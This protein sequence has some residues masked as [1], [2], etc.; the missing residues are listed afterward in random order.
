M[1]LSSGAE[2]AIQQVASERLQRERLQ[3][4]ERDMVRD[5][6]REKTLGRLTR[7]RLSAPAASPIKIGQ[8]AGALKKKYESTI[9]ISG[10][11]D[12]WLQRLLTDT[13][14]NGYD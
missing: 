3:A 7:L 12:S 5:L 9:H 8:S 13:G 4:V 6:N 1:I 14:T 10:A 2:A 11:T